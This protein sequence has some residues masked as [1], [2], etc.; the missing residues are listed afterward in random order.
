MA[1]GVS[2]AGSDKKQGKVSADRKATMARMA[3]QMVEEIRQKVEEQCDYVGDQFA[4]EARKIH[5]GETEERGIYGEASDDQHKEL[6]D[7]GI[8]VYRLP[9]PKRHKH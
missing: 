7:E 8:E 3:S 4:E 5:Y 6:V 1:P 2:T 9:W